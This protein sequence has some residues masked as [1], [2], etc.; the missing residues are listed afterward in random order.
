MSYEDFAD[1]MDTCLPRGIPPNCI[2]RP[3]DM[4]Q[5]SWNESDSIRILIERVADLDKQ[6]M[7]LRSWTIRIMNWLGLWN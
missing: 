6:I 7:S 1:Y 4:T 5:C 2:Q 3:V